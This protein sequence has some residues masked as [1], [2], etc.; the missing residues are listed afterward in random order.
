M[1]GSGLV[2]FSRFVTVVL[3]ACG[4]ATPG[5]DIGKTRAGFINRI[6][7]ASG[8]SIMGHGQQWLPHQHGR[9]LNGS[10]QSPLT[11]DSTGYMEP[12]QALGHELEQGPQRRC[13]FIGLEG[14]F[15]LE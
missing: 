7:K 2:V 5:K 3:M 15:F 11:L 4:T 6:E 1:R 8:T 10:C 12:E 9:P 13:F 14:F